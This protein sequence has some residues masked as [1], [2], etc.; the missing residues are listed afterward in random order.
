MITTPI[1]IYIL[2]NLI[3][4]SNP[5]PIYSFYKIINHSNQ[6]FI[7][8]FP[9]PPFHSSTTTLWIQSQLII[10]LS[11]IIIQNSW[12]LLYMKDIQLQDHRV[13]LWILWI[14]VNIVLGF[15]WTWFPVIIRIVF[16]ICSIWIFVITTIMDFIF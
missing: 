6:S 14:S 12:S 16:S 5:T 3:H 15:S 2:D 10:L 8:I 1:N 9:L 11:Q 13:I 4:Y 7:F